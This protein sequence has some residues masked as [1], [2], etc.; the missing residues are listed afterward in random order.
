MRKAFADFLRIDGDLI[1]AA[2]QRSSARASPAPH[3][4]MDGFIA[5][6]PEAEKTAWLV[7]LTAG[8]GADVQGEVLRR[9]KT[10]KRR[11]EARPA[12]S[13]TVGIFSQRPIDAGDEACTAR[14]ETSRVP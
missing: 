14:L 10:A 2:A 1:A 11:A 13:R 5:A 6:L 12:K 4:D 3:T 8:D 9:F 7:R